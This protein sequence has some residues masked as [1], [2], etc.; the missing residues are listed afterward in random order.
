MEIKEQKKEIRKKIREI[1]NS[2]PKEERDSLS[3]SVQHKILEMEELKSAHTI[4]LYYSLPDEVST[5]FLLEKLSNYR[6]GDK[7]IILP[8]VEGDILILKEY[9]PEQIST[10]YRNISEPSGGVC[11]DPAEIEFAII[12]GMAFDTQCNRMGRGKGF[13]DRLIPSLKCKKCG[14]GF[15]FQIVDEVPCQDFDKPLDIV[16]TEKDIFYNNL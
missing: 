4:L 15:G 8:V 13:Y 14:M 10:G 16:V 2:I 3:L 9:V 7:R 6:N 11:T 12:P 5:E 1:K